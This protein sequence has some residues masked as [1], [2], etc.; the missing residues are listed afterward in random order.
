MKKIL[1]VN[2]NMKVGGV[3]KALYNLLWEIDGR[4]EVTLCLFSRRGEYVDKLPPSVRVVEARGAY[5]YLGVSQGECKGFDALKRGVCVGLCRLIGRRKTLKFL[6]RRQPSFGEKFD[7]AI[8]Y[9]HNGR[10]KSF[11]GGTQ[12][13]VL[14]CVAAERKVAFLHCDYG[15]CGANNTENNHDMKR[16][17]KIAAC[18]DGCRK[19]FISLLPHLAD[20]CITVRNCHRFDEIHAMADDDPVVYGGSC[21]NILIVA[22]LSHEKG[23]DRAIIAVS[24]AIKK[25]VSVKLHIVGGGSKMRDLI[26]LATEL[27]ISGNVTFYG[28]QKNPYRYMKNADVLMI[29][30]YH[31][32][33]PMVIDE[34]YALGLPILTTKTTSSDD[35]VAFR[36]CG[37][38]CSNSQDGINDTLLSICSSKNQIILKKDLLNNISCSNEEAV[39]Q[40]ESMVER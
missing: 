39:L 24:E 30:S 37:W 28:E 12:D 26:D 7:C 34:A 1:I 2:N 36:G 3:Q 13:F 18:S 38:V 19:A 20:K 32:A 15:N 27:G 25:S 17:D 14:D 40:F 6:K 31:E 8:S 33:A 23:I 16:F 21:V 10:S 4:Y 22:R 9:L 11:Y 29:S 35:M 5:R